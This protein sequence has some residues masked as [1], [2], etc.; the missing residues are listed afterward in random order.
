MPV[1]LFDTSTT[2]RLVDLYNKEK[3]WRRAA[4]RGVSKL[5]RLKYTG[6]Y[7]LDV[8]QSVISTDP[9]FGTTGGA[10]LALSD[11]LGNEQYYFLLYNT[12]ETQSDLLSSFNIA[13]SRMSMGQR[14]NYAYGIYRFSGRRYDITDPDLFFYERVFGGYF[15][16]E[17]PP[18]EV[19]AH[20]DRGQ[21]QQF[22]QGG[23]CAA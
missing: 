15:A 11:L 9:V 17:L 4:S 23:G 6:Q 10:Q 8:A 14:T 3:P 18:V 22:Q 2:V 21:P 20:R 1:A 7:S 13:I 12:A 16:A 19:R 5:Q